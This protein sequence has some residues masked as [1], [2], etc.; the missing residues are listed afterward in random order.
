MSIF[1]KLENGIAEIKANFATASASASRIAEL[2]TANTDLTAKLATANNTAATY[3]ATLADLTAKLTKAEADLTASVSKITAL[4]SD[5]KTVG[6]E[7]A[8]V[9]AALGV[10]TTTIPAQAA[11][12][13]AS[14][15]A[16][17]L[18]AKLKT[19]NSSVEK[20]KI[21]EQIKALSKK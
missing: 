5:K 4:E 18:R 16:T 13:D 17:E 2:E 9:V 10:D 1:Q 6:A 19:T 7:A 21:C 3:D 8:A 12:P 11:K 15:T 14:Q 20:F